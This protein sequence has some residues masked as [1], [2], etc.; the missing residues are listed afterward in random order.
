VAG[1]VAIPREVHFSIKPVIG[2]TFI[3]FLTKLML[4]G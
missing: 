3:V 4:I 1:A 2:Q